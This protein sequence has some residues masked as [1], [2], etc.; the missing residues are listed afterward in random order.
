MSSEINR[1]LALAQARQSA[2]ARW[3]EM[4]KTWDVLPHRVFVSYSHADQ[5]IAERV[6]AHLDGRG[7]ANFLFAIDMQLA[8]EINETVAKE[9]AK[10]THLLL[11][12]TPRSLASHWLAY[13]MGYARA[14]EKLILTF[15]EPATLE[16]PDIYRRYHYATDLARLQI[17]FDRPNF[18]HSALES[19]VSDVLGVGTDERSLF[20]PVVPLP[21]RASGCWERPLIW[22]PAVGG[23]RQDGARWTFFDRDG[24]PVVGV[25]EWNS[26]GVK[27]DFRLEYQQAVGGVRLIPLDAPAPDR[28]TRLYPTDGGDGCTGWKTSEAFWR[29]AVGYLRQQLDPTP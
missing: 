24:S 5:A 8:D 11:I 1:Q 4:A 25:R 16:L 15:V 10:C 23:K 7:I 28:G 2:G 12:V 22:P 6:R 13:E 29:T 27:W 9:I 18:P 26:A 14:K 17:Y 19:F 3:S 21:D 20:V